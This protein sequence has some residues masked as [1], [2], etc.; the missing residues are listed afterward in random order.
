MFNTMVF[1]IDMV[2]KYQQ[3]DTNDTLFCRNFHFCTI[4]PLVVK[5]ARSKD[6]MIQH[7]FLILTIIEEVTANQIFWT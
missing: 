2:S 4:T 1:A 7:L 3:P 6:I 5:L